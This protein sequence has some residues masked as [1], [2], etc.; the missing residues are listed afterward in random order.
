MATRG[1]AL[2][3]DGQRVHALDIVRTLGRAGIAVTVGASSADAIAF[4]SRYATRC[5]VYPDP[6]VNADEFLDWLERVLEKGECDLVIPVTDVTLIP[7][8]R[9]LERLQ[10]LCA[11]AA[12]PF[13]V[14]EQVTDKSR[15]LDLARRVGVPCPQT[16]VVHDQAELD[17]HASAM[18][19]PVVCKPMASGVWSTNGYVGLQV[20]YALDE[21]ELRREVARRLVT[22]PVMLQEY[23]RGAGVGVEVLARDGKILQAFQHQRL[24]ELPLTGG[25]STYRM[26]VRVDPVLLDYAGR[27][28]GA[29]GWTGVAMVEF[30]VDAE[31]GNIA[32]ME[33]NGR[34]WGS[35]PLS[36]RAGM[37]FAS[38]LFDM[39][40]R[41]ATVPP[42]AYKS[43][44]RC[45]KLRDDIEWFKEAW[46]LEPADPHVRAG[47]IRIVPKTTLLADATR[48]L[49][50]REHYDVQMLSDPRPGLRDLRDTAIAQV[51]T[52]KR[53]VRSMQ[54]RVHSVLYRVRTR[55]RLVPRARAARNL[56]FV[57]YGNIM[58]SPFA[59]GYL[60]VRGGAERRNLQARSAGYYDRTGRPADARAVAAGRQWGVDLSS[61]S[62]R[63][64]D[65]DLV[66]WADLILVMDRPNLSAV[67]QLYPAAAEKTYLLGSLDAGAADVEIADP[68][69]CPYEATERTYVRIA[70]AIDRL[71]ACGASAEAHP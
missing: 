20:F 32:L 22:C 43:G 60:A 62:S 6:A 70:G 69:H 54:R 29:I 28:L 59:S 49:S 16:V 11:I 21:Q 24:H 15:T 3:L 68:Y 34:F 65:D 52:L 71:V 4:S 56:L 64:L 44:V 61:H 30:R 50:P 9:S 25:G 5:E 35:L 66:A 7:I 12:Q 18:R 10:R 23:R 47:L 36:S 63:K 2:V 26:S 1:R 13:D 39:L 45:R 17:R 37:A 51:T 48:L 58:R 40:V 27:L 38:D 46:K 42:R 14:L 57:C 67:R 33:I 31:T 55:P 53:H 19:F 41:G 8:A